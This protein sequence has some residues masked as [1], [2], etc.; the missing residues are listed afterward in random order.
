MAEYL[1]EFIDGEDILAAETNAN[2]NYLLD[3]IR[4]SS[5]VLTAKINSLTSQ[6]NTNLQTIYPIGAIYIGT[7]ET[8]PIANLFGTWEKVSEGRVLQGADEEHEAGT[9]IPAGLPNL[10]GNFRV[11]N[12]WPTK[13]YGISGSNN[14]TSGVFTASGQW[15]TNSAGNGGTGARGFD[16]S[17]NAS[18]GNSVYGQSD[19]VQPPAFVVNIWRRTA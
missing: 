6:L 12:Q 13:G 3:Q 2:N 7:T 8:C 19:T 4:D 15:G 10:E 18:S 9:T 14:E 1:K 5:S 16:Y 11:T 17:F